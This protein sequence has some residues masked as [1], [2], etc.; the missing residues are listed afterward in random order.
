LLIIILIIGIV[1]AII[2][3]ILITRTIVNPLRLIAE[4]M[5]RVAEGDIVLA[6]LDENATQ[7]LFA[8]RDELGTVGRAISNL[9]EK[10]VDV[11][12]GMRAASDEVESGSTQ[13]SNTAQALSQGTTEQAASIEELSASVEEL[14][15]TVKQNADN[16][17]QA[18]AL[19]R[20]VAGNADASGKSVQKTVKSM[21]EIASRIS[22][23]E[24]IARQT[25]LLA[26]NA[27][28]EAARAGE[29]GK[30]FAVVASEVRKLAERSQTAA[31]E[32]NDLSRSSVAVAE[33]AGHLLEELVPDI[34]KTADL[35]QEITAAS[36]EQASGAEQIAKGVTQMD[37]VVQENAAASE[38]LAS[39]AEE[40]SAQ[41]VLLAERVSF[42]KLSQ[43][44]NAST[45]E[46]TQSGLREHPKAAAGRIYKNL[47]VAIKEAP[48][49][50]SPRK[51]AVST[52]LAL[53]KKA[54][55]AEKE[56]KEF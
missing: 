29:A 25:N 22:I 45:V 7:K 12:S 16:T 20:R 17:S 33:E 37:S 35:I 11:A 24:E 47:G 44:A 38:E 34:R 42:F 1:V 53:S 9:K 39:T 30:G 51:P 56:D 55:P 10:L 41:A 13:L 23:I 15:A 28:I 36:S 43:N 18:D 49:D 26:L 54:V 4:A 40:L 8:R 48:R 32:I 6:G 19:S 2:V 5:G 46:S 21:G 31:A 50:V 52:S 3:A 27:A 14:A